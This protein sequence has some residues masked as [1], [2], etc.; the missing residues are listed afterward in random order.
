VLGHGGP[1]LVPG[2]DPRPWT[3][4]IP[5]SESFDAWQDQL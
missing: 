5:R 3:G 4:R 1:P 2:E